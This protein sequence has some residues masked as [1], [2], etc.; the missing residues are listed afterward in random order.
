MAFV[1]PL[2]MWAASAAAST[3]ATVGTAAVAAGS[4][5]AAAAPAWSTLAMGATALSGGVGAYGAIK[6]GEAA[7]DAAEFNAETNRQNA[8]I[9][10]ENANIAGQ[11]GAQQAANESM[12]TRATVGNIK[13]N[14]AASGVDVLSGSA[15]DVQ[16]SQAELGELDALTLR[17]NATREA[18]GY[19]NAATNYKNEESLNRAEADNDSTAGSINAA[20]TLLG[21][22]GSASSKYYDWKREGSL[23]P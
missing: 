10:K 21:T 4:A 14:Q 23:V 18:F 5:V 6:Q 12:K 20:G 16:V 11:S 7:A 19:R 9:A 1:I 15:L 17:S 8:E 3:A 13:A 2:A 22:L